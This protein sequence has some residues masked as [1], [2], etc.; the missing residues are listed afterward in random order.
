MPQT[1]YQK[2]YYAENRDW[3]LAQQS[4]RYAL[5]RGAANARAKKW[6]K[7]NPEKV[8]EYQQRYAQRHP[9]KMASKQMAHRAKV[10]KALF[11]MFGDKCALCGFSDPRALQI[12]HVYGC[13][14]SVADRRKH[15]E[16]GITFWKQI[17]RG[18]R[19]RSLYQ[20]LCANCNWIKRHQNGENGG[21]KL[22]R[23][24]HAE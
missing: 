2:R 12:D 15:H 16:G 19:D 17:L 5:N 23:R 13:P 11:A 22:M 20:L 9:D 6:Q 7:A 3:I 4:A 14:V 21:Y 10:K 1:E 18:E 24:V 8:K